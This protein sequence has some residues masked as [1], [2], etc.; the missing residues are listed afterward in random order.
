MLFHTNH[1]KVNAARE[2]NQGVDGFSGQHAGLDLNT[3]MFMGERFDDL[4]ESLES[5]TMNLLGVVTRDRYNEPFSAPVVSFGESETDG[6]SP[7]A[8]GAD[9]DRNTFLAASRIRGRSAGDN[10]H[11]CCRH[12][13]H[14][15]RG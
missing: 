13:C 6:C 11:R 5:F 14:G 7:Y 8:L 2:V 9:R 12:S 4:S 15:Y 1:E 10:H 3:G